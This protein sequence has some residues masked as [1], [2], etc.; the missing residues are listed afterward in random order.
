M[1]ANELKQNVR[2]WL[3]EDPDTEGTH[4][5]NW[6]LIYKRCGVHG[7]EAPPPEEKDERKEPGDVLV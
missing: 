7:K 3:A 5:K 4:R 2:I 1:S 6:S